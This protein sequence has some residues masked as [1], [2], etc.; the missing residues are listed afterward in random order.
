MHHIAIDI[1]KRVI[2]SSTYQM[3]QS[4]NKNRE[5]NIKCKY[6]Q[7]CNT[8][9]HSTNSITNERIVDQDTVLLLKYTFSILIFIEFLKLIDKAFVNR[10]RISSTIHLSMHCVYL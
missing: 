2:Q 5:K 7:C 9:L 10:Y 8:F 4:N 1:I 3:C 6:C